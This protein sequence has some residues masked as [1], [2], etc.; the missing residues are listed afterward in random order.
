M[1]VNNK[2]P[3]VPTVKTMGQTWTVKVYDEF[4]GDESLQGQC[5]NEKREIHYKSTMA[6]EA[7]LDTLLHEIYHAY[8]EINRIPADL[9]GR[10][11]ED[12]LEYLAVWQ[13]ACTIDLIRGNPELIKKILEGK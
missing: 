10:D 12:W 7:Q 2:K 9:L 8:Q 3:I 5:A 4:V 13:A 11:L 6:K 1:P